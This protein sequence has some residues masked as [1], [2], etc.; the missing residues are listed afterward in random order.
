MAREE[1]Q[2][3]SFGVVFDLERRI[4]KIDRFRIPLPYGLPL[5]SIGYGVAALAAVLTIG[6]L[7]VVGALPAALP[8]PVRF[9]L[10]PCGVAWALTGLRVDGRP[11]HAA[12]VAIA[13]Y[14][15]SPRRT[16]CWARAPTGPQ[17][18]ADLSIVS[19][20]R[21]ATYRRAVV[22][23]PA[24]VLLRGAFTARQHRGRMIIEPAG[25]R[26]LVNGRRLELKPGQRLVM[27]CGR[28]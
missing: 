21:S 8:A 11:A 2:L 1:L 6:R 5:R 9:A 24:R 7:P 25:D 12:G 15:A 4:H 19:D 17:R 10:L 28:R 26:H 18:L 20:E 16:A 13:R 14:V 22:R 23:G 3:R 27:R